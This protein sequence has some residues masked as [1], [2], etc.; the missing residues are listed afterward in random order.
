MAPKQKGTVVDE[1]PETRRL[2]REAR[3]EKATAEIVKRREAGEKWGEIAEAVELSTGKVMFMYE[4]SQVQPKD[5]IKYKDDDELASKIVEAREK[6][7]SWGTI[8][9]RA[10]IGEGKA[11]KLYSDATGEDTKGLRVGKGGR[12]ASNGSGPAKKAAKG[13]AAA[14]KATQAAVNKRSAG[15]V[16]NLNDMNLEEITNR[17]TGK[18]IT[19]GRSGKQTK[20]L[21]KKVVALAKGEMAFSDAKGASRTVKVSDIVKASR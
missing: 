2:A 18:T 11:R 14:K 17:L 4:V 8:M 15:P 19:L 21:V 7:Q 12:P 13:S 9:A 20:A 16:K 10:N 1:T 3:D 5:R 6:G